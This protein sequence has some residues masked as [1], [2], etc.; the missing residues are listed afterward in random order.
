MTDTRPPLAAALDLQPHP[1]GGWF[2][3]TWRTTTEFT[4][5]GYPGVRASATGIYFLLMPG[6]HSAPH[7]VTS[8]EVWLWHRGGPLALDIAGTEIILGPDIEAGQRPQALVPGGATQSAR[9]LTHT[10]ALVS[11]VVSPGFDFADFRMD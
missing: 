11:C 9:P 8:D 10:Y 1:E 5:D 3:E 2:R 4:P 6:E 7:T